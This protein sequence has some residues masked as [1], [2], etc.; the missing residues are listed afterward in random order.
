MIFN[1]FCINSHFSVFPF[2]GGKDVKQRILGDQYAKSSY[3]RPLSKKK[4]TL[5]FHVYSTNQHSFHTKHI[6]LFISQSF[7][8]GISCSRCDDV[9][10]VIDVIRAYQL[11]AL[12]NHILL[13]RNHQHLHLLLCRQSPQQLAKQPHL[14]HVE[15]SVDFVGQH[16]GAGLHRMGEQ[17]LR[18][19]D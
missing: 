3:I 2:V 14:V 1:P 13:M 6:Q 8:I 11:S 18:R 5:P 4:S 16:D 17:S 12:S 10:A 7:W 9:C 15:R 19:P